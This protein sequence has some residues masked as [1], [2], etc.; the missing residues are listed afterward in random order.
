LG[1][2]EFIRIGDAARL[3]AFHLGQRFRSDGHAHLATARDRLLQRA[4]AGA[5]PVVAGT[6]GIAGTDAWPGAAAWPL[7]PECVQGLT[8]SS[9][10]WDASLFDAS[11][12]M[13]VQATPVVRQ[14]HAGPATLWVPLPELAESF[15]IDAATIER[16]HRR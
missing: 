12:G 8:P 14:L 7:P 10:D 1:S 2:D 6:P 16:W 3:L 11:A 15:G 9:I 4:R 5:L 13:P